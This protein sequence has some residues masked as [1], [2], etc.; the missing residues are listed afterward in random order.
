MHINAAPS[1]HHDQQQPIDLA[2]FCSEFEHSIAE[3]NT[4]FSPLTAARQVHST[5]HMDN[6]NTL[7]TTAATPTAPTTTT[8]TTTNNHDGQLS[9]HNSQQDQ[10]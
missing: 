8:I 4:F 3:M 10:M 7:A 6:S 1:K 5:K 2:A 9:C